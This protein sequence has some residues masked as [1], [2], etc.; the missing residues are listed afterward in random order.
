MRRRNGQAV[1]SFA[2]A[3]LSAAFLFCAPASAE[4][5][6][7]IVVDADTDTVL[8]VRHADEPRYPASLTKV[9][10]LYMLFDEMKAGRIS[11]DDRMTVSRTAAAQPP[12]NLR[13]RRGSTITVR[14]AI[15][16]LITKSANDVAV[17]VAEHIGGT[18]TRFARLMTVKANDL[19]MQNTVFRN[20]SGLPN[21]RQVS[22][23]RDMAEL[24]EAMLTDHADYYGYFSKTRFSYGGRTYK[25]HNELLETVEG[26]DGIKTGYTRASGFNLMASADRDGR[27]IIAVMLGGHTSK[28]RNAHVEAL[29]EAAYDAIDTSEETEI[30]VAT[31]T[32][33]AFEAVMDPIAPNAAA[34]PML[35]GKPFPGTTR[36]R[37][38]EGLQS[39]IVA[40]TKPVARPAVAPRLKPAPTAV[41][42]VPAAPT[43]KPEPTVIAATPAP[44][45]APTPAPAPKAIT[46][47]MGIAEAAARMPL[48]ASAENAMSIAEYEAAQFGKH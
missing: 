36:S 30:P 14:A 43:R 25:N 18:E 35:N 13:L 42:S 22:T 45:P 44:A 21:S 38:E 31:A 37:G 10:T 40:E 15:D 27:R 46:K 34:V 3:A 26:V 12:S 28:S 8:H 4:K 9:M 16:A 11:L 5:Y 39:I 20:A 19:G 32:R 2:A 7:S 33:I 41:A 47:P 29:I 6:A 1:L 17:V 48:R 23:A 24:A